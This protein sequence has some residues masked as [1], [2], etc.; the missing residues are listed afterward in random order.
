MILETACAPTF[1]AHQTFHPRFGWLKKGLDGVALNP[2]IFSEPSATLALGVGKN[3][4]DAIRFWCSAFG[5]TTKIPAPGRGRGTHDVPTNIGAAFFSEQGFDPYMEDPTTLWVLHWRA[6]SPVSALPVWWLAFNRFSGREFSA[7]DLV[8]FVQ[9]ELAGASWASPNTSSLVKD[10]DCMVRMYASRATRGRQTVDDLIDSPFRELGVMS[11]AAPGKYR[12]VVGDKPLL[13]STAIAYASLDF[14]ASQLN[15]SMSCSFSKL[16][17]DHS[18]PGKIMKLNEATLAAALEEVARES[19]EISLASPGGSMQLV[20]H[21]EPV[22]VAR[23][24]L[25][26]HYRARGLDMRRVP[27]VPVAGPGARAPLAQLSLLD[28]EVQAA[29]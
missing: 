4:V 12:F 22:S 2:G 6:L 14:M 7:D 8:A 28:T 20:V 23:R 21:E 10:V 27:R 19:A 16:L 24:V 17:N 5:L 1:A 3:M 18:S 26:A 9:D 15:G 11:P 13:S 29:I 25:V